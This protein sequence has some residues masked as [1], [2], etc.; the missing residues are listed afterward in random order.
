MTS[1]ERTLLL[2]CYIERDKNKT[3]FGARAVY[4]TDANEV[5]HVIAGSNAMVMERRDNGNEPTTMSHRMT[6]KW[7]TDK[8]I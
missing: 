1:N 5:G 8:G 7:K 4:K 3:A 2:L 6:W